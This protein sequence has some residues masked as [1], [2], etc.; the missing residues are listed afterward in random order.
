M[1]TRRHILIG[2]IGSASAAT[3][4]ACAPDTTTAESPTPEPPPTP[5]PSPTPEAPS[6]TPEPTPEPAPEPAVL[7]PLTWLPVADPN[8][9]LGPAVALK[10]PNLKQ[11]NPQTAGFADADMWFCQPNG[12]AATR[13]V[14]VFHSTYPE[15]VGPIRSMRPVDV[16]LFSPLNL[17]LG[18][19]GAADWVMKYIKAHDDNLERMT[20]LEWRDTGAYTVDRSRV[21]KA[22]GK[23]QFD[24]AIM[25][26]PA[27]MALKAERMK[28]APPSDYLPFVDDPTAASTANGSPASHVVVPYG[29]NHAMSYEFDAGSG[30][31]AR[32]QPWGAHEV[33]GGTRLA[34]ENVLIIQ[35]KWWYDK[36]WKGTGAADPVVDI[37]DST[38]PFTYLN[39]GK[40]VT[41]TWTKGGLAEKF[42]FAL[43]DGSPLAVAPGRTWIELPHTKAEISVSA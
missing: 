20:Y 12:D 24:R 40:A 10:V 38:G 18:N 27:V 11:E 26:H 8:S 9:V 34:S 32:S 41:G 19:T 30:R 23:N 5:T 6:P 39:Q 17:I 4:A 7:A 42:V 33:E 1:T 36:I 43:D 29:R 21:Y 3:L 15:A 37:I 25:A 28:A 14:P 35:A 22:N 2:L 16:P 13:L 31:Y